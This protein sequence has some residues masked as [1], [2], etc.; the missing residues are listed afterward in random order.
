MF[1]CNI[2]TIFLKL[3]NVKNLQFVYKAYIYIYIYMCVCV[4][5]CVCSWAAVF[6]LSMF[7]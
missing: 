7:D 1:H 3:F 4:C 6:H 5:V 2:F